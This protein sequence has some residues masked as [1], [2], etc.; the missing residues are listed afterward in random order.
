[1]ILRN[2]DVR[3]ETSSGMKEEE[4]DKSISVATAVVNYNKLLKSVPV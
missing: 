2:N 1:M 4:A 3:I